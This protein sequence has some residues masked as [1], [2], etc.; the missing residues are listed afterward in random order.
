MG[1]LYRVCSTPQRNN[2]SG[3]GRHGAI[4]TEGRGSQ[5]MKVMRTQEIRKDIRE[6]AVRT[7]GPLVHEYIESKV[8][9]VVSLLLRYRMCYRLELY[10][11]FV[12]NGCTVIFCSTD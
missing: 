5:D 3:P 11:R 9:S 8:L 12:Y 1:V 10:L 6:R 2:K 4:L 7:C